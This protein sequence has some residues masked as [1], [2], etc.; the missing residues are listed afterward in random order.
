[1]I[2]SAK[3]YEIRFSVSQTISHG[4]WGKVQDKSTKPA[5][6]TQDIDIIHASPLFLKGDTLRW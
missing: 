2:K 1:M 4:Q 6:P 5:R 3:D